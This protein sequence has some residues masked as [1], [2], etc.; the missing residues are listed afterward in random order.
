MEQ[1]RYDEKDLR[2]TRQGILKKEEKAIRCQSVSTANCF[3]KTVSA[4]YISRQHKTL[5]LR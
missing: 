4:A 1:S 2:Q 3:G 5:I